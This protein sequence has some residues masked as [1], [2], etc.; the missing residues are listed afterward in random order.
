MV[1]TREKCEFLIIPIGLSIPR[2]V[3]FFRNSTIRY[4]KVLVFFGG[5]AGFGL[6]QDYYGKKLRAL[7]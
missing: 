3:I 5:V 2:Y 4:R 6:A 1:M 7:A